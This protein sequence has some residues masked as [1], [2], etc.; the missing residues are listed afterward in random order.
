MSSFNDFLTTAL[1]PPQQQA[2]TTKKQAILVIAGAGSGKTRIITAR[3]AH[4]ILNEQVPAT[5]I[6]ALTFTNKAAGEM[7]ERISSFLEEKKTLPY[8]G[9]FHSYCLLLLRSNP[10][11]TDH[12]VF[13]ILDGEDQEALLKRI[14]KQYGLEKR[15]TASAISHQISQMKNR[16]LDEEDIFIQPIFKDVYV[17]YEEEKRRSNSFDFDDLILTML[18]IFKT[19]KEFVVRFQQKVRHIL[20]DEYQDTNSVQH[21]LLKRMGL[22]P[23]LDDEPQR[24]AVD[25]ICAVGDEDQSI[26]S[27]RGAAVTNMLKFKDDFAPVDLIKI[28][29][30]YR[31]AQPILKAANALIEYN[32]VRTPKNLW[33]EKKATNRIL[34]VSAQSEYQEA[35]TVT[36]L[37]EQIPATTKRNNIAILYRTHFQSR[38]IEE[39]LMQKSIPYKI[40][41][42]IRFYERKEIKD[43][44]AYLKLIANP[45]D[46]AAFFRIINTPNRGLGQ[47]FELDA[48]VFWTKNPMLNFIQMLQQ[49]AKDISSAL[50]PVRKQAVD[51]FLDLFEGLTL[52]RPTSYLLNEILQRT[53]Y[54]NFLK[55][56]LDAHEAETKV[57]NIR[58]LV[59]SIKYFEQKDTT[60]GEKPTLETFLHEIALMQEK[61]ASEDGDE[62][63]VQM[64][65]LHAVK[66][67][68]FDVVIIIGLEEGLLPST[69]SLHS[70]TA[71]EEE[72]RLFYVGITRAREYLMI[73]HAETRNTYGQINDQLASRFLSELPENLI[74]HIKAKYQHASQTRMLIKT[75]L[76]NNI[77]EMSSVITFGSATQTKPFTTPKPTYSSSSSY[78]SK[79]T[80]NKTTSSKPSYIGKTFSMPQKKT[81]TLPSQLKN[82]A[83][84]AN[85]IWKKNSAISH[86]TFGIGIIKSAEKKDDQWFVT[87]IFSCGEKKVLSTFLTPL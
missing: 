42:G 59:H 71:L 34:C 1:N 64:M 43:L 57:E 70:T 18:N 60:S 82:F 73:L 53:Q 32:T 27:W 65:T 81:I 58:E 74:Y 78:Q 40:I 13:S 25:S 44:L 2:V 77:T 45:F 10:H 84:I 23:E 33:S 9:T 6:V 14:I 30:N 5:A 85:T 76:G 72:R 7:R 39:A 86:N 54:Q 66:G 48:Q 24:V 46:R 68:E 80:T 11:L 35:D 37:I 67:L 15:V 28:E 41:G 12:T 16:L 26:Y 17:A 75:F 61:I 8:V 38:S 52:E 3:I 79:P 62:N 4:L 63:C 55:T 21:E 47:K 87:A 20:V 29:Q 56:S 51:D 83:D 50:G 49:F 36:Q 19:N 22:T 69:R 31:S